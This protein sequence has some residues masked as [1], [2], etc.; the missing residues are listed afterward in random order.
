MQ[1]IMVRRG[2][3]Y[4][5]NN[6]A[7][8]PIFFQTF[9]IITHD[10]NYAS[11]SLTSEPPISNGSE[12]SP[13]VDGQL[14]PKDLDEAP[15]ITSSRDLMILLPEQQREIIAHEMAGFLEEKHRFMRE[16]V[17]WDDSANE[18]V[19]LAK[20]MCDIM[21]EMTNF[22]RGTGSLI[23]TMDVIKQSHRRSPEVI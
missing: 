16:V 3:V 14:K 4:L 13:S 12:V 6:Q 5:F 11:L 15:T 23:T 20:Q 7:S 1:S 17:K 19:L 10:A 21:M 2:T 8:S 22:T 18:I 9:K